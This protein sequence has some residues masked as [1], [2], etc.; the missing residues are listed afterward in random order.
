M[1][2]GP[3]IFIEFMRKNAPLLLPLPPPNLPPPALYPLL[4][5]PATIYLPL[6]TPGAQALDF[7]AD[8]LESLSIDA[9]STLNPT[10]HSNSGA[11]MSAANREKG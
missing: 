5:R 10:H 2:E 8:L 4:L 3:V 1:D 7:N 11:G 6:Q 9:R